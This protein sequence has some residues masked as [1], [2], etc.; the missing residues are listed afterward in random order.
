ML[1]EQPE[2]QGRNLYQLSLGR[3]LTLEHEM[4]FALRRASSA[5][6][7]F[8]LSINAPLGLRPRERQNARL[9]RADGGCGQWAGRRADFGGAACCARPSAREHKQSLIGNRLA[10]AEGKRRKCSVCNLFDECAPVECSRSPLSTRPEI[11]RRR[12]FICFWRRVAKW[13]QLAAE[14][15]KKPWKW[16]SV[17]P[18]EDDGRH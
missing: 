9:Q 7:P 13:L 6:A 4:I 17:R 8:G 2:E 5:G 3:K 14:E 15:R 16:H 10:A 11:G 1:A 12:K 18:I